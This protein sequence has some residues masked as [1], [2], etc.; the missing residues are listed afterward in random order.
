MTYPEIDGVMAVLNRR[1]AHL[2]GVLVHESLQRRFFETLCGEL[3][4]LLR[5]GLRLL[6]V[7]VVVTVVTVVVRGELDDL[8]QGL[9]FVEA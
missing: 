5:V 8:G 1:E 7:V 6:V 2:G 9:V 4:Q 3:Q